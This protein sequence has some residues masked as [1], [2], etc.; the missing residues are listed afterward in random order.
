M[1]IS[2]TATMSSLARR[3]H[4]RAANEPSGSGNGE[5]GRRPYRSP[6]VEIRRIP[7]IV[8]G[9]SG[10]KVEPGQGNPPKKRP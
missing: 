8:M 3:R 9:G 5:G 10:A 6:C 4:A 7:L 1:E 2:M